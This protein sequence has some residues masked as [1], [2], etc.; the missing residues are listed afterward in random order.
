[1]NSESSG[2]RFTKMGRNG[3]SGS[4]YFDAACE[5]Q[6]LGNADKAIEYLKK[7]VEDGFDK[8]RASKELARLYCDA[9]RYNLALDELAAAAKLAPDDGHINAMM[10]RV[11]SVM[12]DYDPAIGE[13]KKAEKKGYM[14]AEVSRELGLLYRRKRDFHA[15]VEYLEK[16]AVS[17]DSPAGVRVELA[18][19]YFEEKDYEKAQ[20]KLNEEIDSGSDSSQAHELLGSI[21]VRQGRYKEALEEFEAACRMGPGDGRI[22]GEM[23]LAYEKMNDIDKA[24]IK[25]EE[26]LSK[27]PVTARLYSDLGRLY[28]QQ[29]R[30]D[31]AAGAFRNAQKE[32]PRDRDLHLRLAGVLWKKNDYDAAAREIGCVDETEREGCEWNMRLAGIYGKQGKTELAARELNSAIEKGCD[33]GN[34]RIEL[35]RLRRAAGEPRKA[36]EEFRRA[37]E[38]SRYGGE[39]WF[40]NWMLNEIEISGRKVNLDSYPRRIVAGLTNRCNLRCAM[41]EAIGPLWDISERAAEGIVRL[42]P[43]L[44]SIVWVGGEVFLAPGF[45]G[46]FEKASSY[47]QIEQPIC[48]NGLLI[49]ESWCRILSSS[50]VLLTVSIDGVT[51]PTYEK[52]R[53]GADFGVLLDKLEMIAR[54]RKSEGT[55]A[56]GKMRLGMQMV[57]MEENSAE[58]DRVVGFAK[59]FGFEF[60]SLLPLDYCI[61]ENSGL[62]SDERKAALVRQKVAA[63]AEEAAESGIQLFDNLPHPNE[64]PSDKTDD[65]TRPEGGGNET[66]PGL[67]CHWPWHQLNLG[68]NDTVCIHCFCGNKPVGNSREEELEAIWNGSAIRLAREKIASGRS[69]EWCNPVCV[70]GKIKKDA[71]CW[72]CVHPGII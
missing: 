48:T 31:L 4:G 44:Q 7:A 35:G 5:Q 55:P 22:C 53:T 52:I 64:T 11:Y 29:R 70:S 42:M 20:E 39:K 49:D 72:E 40:S 57:V 66:E 12:T 30:Y 43:Y 23:G 32:S 41:C 56:G 36:A 45:R 3:G 26:A 10:G 19:I 33:E 24:V 68:T 13:Y 1:M 37:L 8:V 60:L 62:F 54:Y 69:G 2:A 14:T 63:L 28:E 15:A 50:R 27:G 18:R 61:K 71:L 21:H 9:G 34:A 58:L 67:L 65:R 25:Y 17:K 47:P 59:K 51:K 46:L 16:A 38:K 6:R